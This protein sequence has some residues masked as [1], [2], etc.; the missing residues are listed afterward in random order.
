M[1]REASARPTGRFSCCCCC[2]CCCCCPPP[3]VSKKETR[4]FR[5]ADVKLVARNP[6]SSASLLSSPSERETTK[7]GSS[8]AR[9]RSPSPRPA[10]STHP[11]PPALLSCALVPGRS[12]LP[13]AVTSS[14]AVTS[15]LPSASLAGCYV[16]C[17]KVSLPF[18]AR[19]PSIST[20]WDPG[21]LKGE[22]LSLLREGAVPA[23]AVVARGP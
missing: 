12:L 8:S 1:R 7:F 13:P 5:G 10:M 14:P 4:S 23:V 3:A 11:P 21:G 2:C 6:R 16:H 15:P 18:S 17:W 9:S 22:K 19:N 20:M